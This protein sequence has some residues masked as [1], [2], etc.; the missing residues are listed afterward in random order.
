LTKTVAPS[1]RPGSSL[2][3]SLYETLRTDI[4]FAQLRP[5]ERLRSDAL[6]LRYGA[7]VGTLREA[8]NRLRAEGLVEQEDQRGFRVSPISLAELHELTATRCSVNSIAIPESIEHGGA[9]WEEGIVLAFH[10]LSRV[11]PGL[12]LEEHRNAMEM[13][14]AF[15]SSL[16]AAC[17]SR[18]L[19]KFADELFDRAVRYQS[20][21]IRIGPKERDPAAEHRAIMEAVLARDSTTTVALLKQHMWSTTKL[22]EPTL[23]FA[24]NER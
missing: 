12:G 20:L 18:F 9:I 4:L 19:I 7:S 1:L 21:S 6:R 13:H 15:H 2:A 17:G 14:R 3:T 24:N 23:S 11:K 10:R 16:F 8:L 5:G 22:L